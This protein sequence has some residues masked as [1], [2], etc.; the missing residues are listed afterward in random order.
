M[1]QQVRKYNTES[2]L[3]LNEIYDREHR[4]TQAD[5]DMAN[6]Y[7]EHIARTRD[8]G[9][10]KV[11]DRLI[12]VSKHGDYSDN[13]IIETIDGNECS[14]CIQPYVPFIWKKP[15]GIDCSV[16]GG[17]FAYI[18]TDGLKYLGRCEAYYQ[19]WGHCGACGNGAVRFIA[20]V[21]RWEY[22]EP[23]PLYGDFTT[24][25]WRKIYLSRMNK[26]YQDYTYYGDGIAFTD[27]G[28]EKFLRDFEAT[29]FEGRGVGSL[30]VWCY[31][32]IVKSISAEE[33]DALDAPTEQRRIYNTP[34]P[35]KII[36]NHDAHERICY[37]VA[38]EFNY[39]P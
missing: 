29:T 19:D 12:Y 4:L 6:D 28:L 22:R 25:S 13:A 30:V 5:A 32:D 2:L 33:W 16:S 37:Y 36:K 14:I 15:D 39:K 7:I 11:G 35:V 1:K 8:K 10:P 23:N 20:E 24:Q 38:P 17:P 21:N 31:R 34:Q 3:L 18:P 27:E 9:T 26:P